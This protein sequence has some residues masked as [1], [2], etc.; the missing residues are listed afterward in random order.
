[1]VVPLN[2]RLESNEEEEEEEQRL[3]HHPQHRDLFVRPVM[4]RSPLQGYTHVKHPP[5]YDH[6]RFLGI[7]LL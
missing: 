4:Y 2:S 1:M 7:A 5:P 6:H 3:Q